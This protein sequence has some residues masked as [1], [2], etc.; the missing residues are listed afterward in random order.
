M[1]IKT[2]KF[3]F[4]MN[5]LLTASNFLFPLITFPY[6]SRVLSPIGTGKVAFAYS[7]ISYFTILA[8][9]GV[10]N[11]G[12]RA[13][14][15]VRDDK[16]QLSKTVQEIL[17]IN[18]VCMVIVYVLFLVAVICVPELNAEKQLFFIASFQILFTIVGLEWLYKG[19]EQYQ[20]IAF[21][22]II[23]KLISLIIIFLC[24]TT[25]D[26]YIIY[27][28]VLVFATVGSGIMNIINL[29]KI[30]FIKRY[31][32]YEIMRHIKPMSIFFISTIAVSIYVN[33]NVV[34]LGFIS[35]NE[36]VGYYNAAYRIRD[37][38]VSVSTALG[39]VLLPRLS[40]YIENNMLDEFN[41]IISKT[42]QFILCFSL[43]LVIFCILFARPAI[44]LLAGLEYEPSVPLLQILSLIILIVG[45]SNLTGIQ[46]LIPLNQEKFFCYS[47]VIGA[48]VSLLLNVL[49]IPKYAAIG[50]AISITLTELSIMCYQLFV[51]RKYILVMFSDISWIK[52]SVAS[53]VSVVIFL[54][55][56]DVV[57]FSRL[58]NF[59]MLSLLFFISYF[60][61]LLI[62]KERFVHSVATQMTKK[63]IYRK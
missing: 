37:L 56:K 28:F 21:R 46:M 16:D 5:L 11:Y 45:V 38:M 42:V 19:I 39:A 35:G 3:N 63:F 8:S 55:V 10:A 44:L 1:K 54:V 15:K 49:L 14:A 17:F 31:E 53:A 20:Y 23:F 34:L 51:L 7:F 59:L 13:V 4:L 6:V 61:I 40:Y 43:P 57:L 32:N 62:L 18:I 60:C 9:F 26:D 12:I 30:I 41:R 58:I 22:S 36:E 25:K 27:A 33:V 48:I 50:A 29:R 52:L 47:L 24:I 2:V